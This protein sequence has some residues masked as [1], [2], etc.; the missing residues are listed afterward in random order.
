M[1]IFYYSEQRVNY[2]FKHPD[3]RG[4]TV[5]TNAST[6]DFLSVL[7]SFFFKMF[8]GAFTKQSDEKFDYFF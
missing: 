4:S 5:Q 6:F 1:I 3:K 2:S 8:I 7:V